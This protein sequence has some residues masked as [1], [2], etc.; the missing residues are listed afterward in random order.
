[1]PLEFL[2]IP[3]RMNLEC[4]GIPI[5]CLGIPIEITLEC[6]ESL[7]DASKSLGIP[8]KILLDCVGIPIEIPLECL[9]IPI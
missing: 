7:L 9:R 1:M 5:C 3:N 8:S 6:M 2:G 4:L